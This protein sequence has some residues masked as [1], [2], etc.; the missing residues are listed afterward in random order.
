MYNGRGIECHEPHVHRDFIVENNRLSVKP[1]NIFYESID[2]ST[3][4]QII[5]QHSKG[6][7]PSGCMACKH[8]E[9]NGVKSRRTQM[10]EFAKN[11]GIEFQIMTEN[12]IFPEK[13]YTRKNYGT[14]GVSRKRRK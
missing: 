12:Q 6:I 1:C 8:N 3:P 13:H 14:R 11:N 2:K 7:W 4:Q 10:N 5:E 9:K